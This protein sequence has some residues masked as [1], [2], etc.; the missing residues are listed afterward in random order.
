MIIISFLNC[1]YFPAD[2]CYN[3]SI[4]D[5]ANRESDYVTP[6]KR[7]FCDTVLPV[8]WYRF[9]GDAGTKMPT[10]RVPAYRCG[11]DWSGWLDG[12][13][14]TVEDGKVK[15]TVCFSDRPSGCKYSIEINVKNCG[16]YFIYNLL[17]LPG[18]NSRY[19]GTD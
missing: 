3:Y 7:S 14:P 12:A 4:L 6:M 8:G 10:T 5:N 13:H 2:S 17:S 11:T 15:R 16:S 1:N 9:K 19:C 18:C